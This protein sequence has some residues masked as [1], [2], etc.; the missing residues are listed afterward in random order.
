MK[1]K[2]RKSNI[3]YQR[4]EEALQQGK[5][6]SIQVSHGGFFGIPV[7][8]D[9]KYVEIVNFYIPDEDDKNEDYQRTV[10]LIKLSEIIAVA[11]PMEMWSKD[12]F[13]QLLNQE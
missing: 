9:S 11:Y 8:L 10:W 2:K 5:E 6:V 1:K 3:L 12:R 13:E 7:Y 4:I